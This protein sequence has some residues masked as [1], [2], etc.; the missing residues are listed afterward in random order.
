MQGGDRVRLLAIDTPER[1]E[2]FYD[3]AKHE[4]AQVTLGKSVRL[5][6]VDNRRDRYGRLLGYAYVDS[7]F[8]N[9]IILENGLGY[10][11][12]FED[13]D[14]SNPLNRELLQAQRSAMDRHVGV[15]SL[16][17]VKEE[18]YLAKDGS[19]RLHRPGCQA[20]A[21]LK[22]GHYRTFKTREEGL[23]EGL[24]PCRICKP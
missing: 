22:Q 23:R 5:E 20:V 9:K 6:Y 15:W 13:D 1:D 24:S 18:Y 4:L 14:L 21:V 7:F 10:L 2:P 11:Y 16:V 17:K 3:E 8:V 12:L 19:F